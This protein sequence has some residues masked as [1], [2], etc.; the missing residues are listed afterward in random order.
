MPSI[1]DTSV[2]IQFWH[3]CRG[4]LKRLPVEKDAKDW[5]AQLIARRRSR[6]IV[7]PV[8]LEFLAG[9]TSAEELRL[10][11]AFLSA[12]TLF[13]EERTLPVDWQEARRLI[14]RVP[15]DGKPRQLGDCLI[16]AIATRLN[17]DVVPVDHRFP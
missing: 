9:A 5:A 7:T 8:Q 11:Q 17:C 1:L 2:L 13:D 10:F 6:L 16:R 3:R 14:Q 4:R 15:R 12:F